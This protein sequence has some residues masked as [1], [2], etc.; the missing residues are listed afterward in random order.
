MK[1][2]FSTCAG[3]SNKRDC[4]GA[5]RAPTSGAGRAPQPEKLTYWKRRLITVEEVRILSPPHTKIYGGESNK[6]SE[7]ARAPSFAGARPA[8]RQLNLTEQFFQNLDSIPSDLYGVS[9][10]DRHGVSVGDRP[11]SCP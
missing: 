11:A 8:P 3:M 2:A 1:N 4:R 7:L 6:L 9:M 10:G 5:G